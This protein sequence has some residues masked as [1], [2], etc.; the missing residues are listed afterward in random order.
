MT[1]PKVLAREELYEMVWSEPITHIAKRLGAS[2]VAISK[3][4]RKMNV[5]RPPRGHWARV[6]HGYPT[7]QPPLPKA[8]P[9]T[10]QEWVLTPQGPRQAFSDSDVD[11]PTIQVPEKL[12][13]PHRTLLTI[14]T[15]LREARRDEYG[16]VCSSSRLIHVTRIH[17]TLSSVTDGPF[18]S[19]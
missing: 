7:S 3:I 6:Q 1:E 4:C 13:K 10:P 14:R 9:E 16:R 5:P 18:S 12:G 19:T 8:K 17:L 11:I 2:D 15:E